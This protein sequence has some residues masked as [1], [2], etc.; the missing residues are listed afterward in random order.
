M[1]KDRDKMKRESEAFLK[2]CRETIT[3]EDCLRWQVAMTPKYPK[4]D[5]KCP[6][7]N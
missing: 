6:P 2:Y 1:R 7:T 3:L 5:D 4:K